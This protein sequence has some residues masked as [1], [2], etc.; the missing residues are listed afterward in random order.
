MRVGITAAE[1]L[2]PRPDAIVVLTDGDTPWPQTPGRA[3][4][5][6][7]VISAQ[8]PAR[9]PSWATTVHIPAGG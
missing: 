7:A 4:L 8:P 2:K 3:K 1:A 9:T 5:V 6:C